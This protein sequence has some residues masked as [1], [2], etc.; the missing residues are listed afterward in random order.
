MEGGLVQI[1]DIAESAADA[2]HYLVNRLTR[3]VTVT[4]EGEPRQMRIVS[5]RDSF[6]PRD[7]GRKYEVEFWDADH[8]LYPGERVS[9]ELLQEEYPG[10]VHILEGTVTGI[11]E[12][13]VSIT[14][15]AVF[16]VRPNT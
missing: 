5:E 6:L 7:S 15:M 8:G 16:D 9:I 2:K 10:S 14:G 4:V 1:S 13:R 12:H 11:E 3:Q